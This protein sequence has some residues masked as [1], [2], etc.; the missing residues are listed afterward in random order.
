MGLFINVEIDEKT[1]V[2]I[3]QCGQC[4]TVCPVSI[5]QRK[6]EIPEIDSDN[7]DECTLCNLCINACTPRSIAI[8]KRYI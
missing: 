5:F 3:Q 4:V 7:E 8:I 2:G 1:C 6:D